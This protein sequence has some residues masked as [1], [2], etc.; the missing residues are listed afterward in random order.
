MRIAWIWDLINYNSSASDA[1]LDVSGETVSL[2]MT[3]QFTSPVDEA[4]IHQVEDDTRTPS[5]IIRN[6]S[7]SLDF[8]GTND[9]S[10]V[11]LD[12]NFWTGTDDM[13]ADTDPNF[14]FDLGQL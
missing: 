7:A 12:T 4:D 11:D 5:G 14:W 6:E 8:H 1:N 2:Q 10:V 3:T 9:A 13:F